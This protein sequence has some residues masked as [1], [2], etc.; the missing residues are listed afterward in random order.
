MHRF[1][2]LPPLSLYVH[3][4]WCVRK[5]PYCDFNS[6]A[7]R[8]ELPESDYV[9]ALLRDLEQDLPRV[10]GRRLN[11]IF[12]G[13]GTPSLLSPD[14]IDRLLAGVRA[15]LPLAPD[16]EIT[17]EANPGASDAERFAGYRA[18]GVNRLS[19]GIQSFDD[20]RLAALGRI[21]GRDEA[22][23]AAEAAR[24]AGFANFNLD[25]MFGLPGQS[26]ESALADV[27]TAMALAP[28]HLSL[29]QLTLE[30]NTPF[31]AQP[32]A[33]PDDDTIAVMQEMLQQTLATGGYAHYEVSAYAQSG[34]HCAHNRNYW[35]FGDY[36]GIGAGAHAKITDHEGIL[37]L[38]RRKQPQD[39]LVSAGTPQALAE[40]RRLSPDETI[41]EFMLNALRLVEGVPAA[42]FSPRTGLSLA[43]VEPALAQAIRRGLLE[44]R[45][46]V[47]RPTILGQRFLND[48]IGLFLP[49]TKSTG[50]C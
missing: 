24:L 26:P 27:H 40:A 49:V 37:R 38:A 35:E 4:P 44:E 10:W 32:P 22:L 14:A 12:I 50:A 9:E 29:Y 18:A 28:S 5:C 31:H 20:T 15:R 41:F 2:A 7:V 46:D 19:I 39:Y 48:L 23:R 42:L 43:V 34:Q 36:L 1:N 17:L 21:H 30:P 16:T 8:G 11:S 33:L 3:V 45:S 6:H 47:I 25:L 13:G